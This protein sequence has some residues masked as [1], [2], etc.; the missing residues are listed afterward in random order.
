MTRLISS[1]F[2]L[3]IASLASLAN[4]SPL[5]SGTEALVRN[6]AS[7]DASPTTTSTP[8]TTTT[9]SSAIATKTIPGCHIQGTP[10]VALTSN[11][12]GAT[13]AAD[14]PSC[15]LSCI[16]ISQCI[17]YSYAPSNLACTLYHQWMDNFTT[18]DT[19]GYVV[20]SDTS[21]LFFSD[22]YPSDGTNFCFGD[23][24]L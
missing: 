1:L 18:G 22:K 3:T 19:T 7:Q 14:F 12:W 21:G 24:Q 17:S 15:Q 2:L 11:V 20:L 8:T 23:H 5:N 10:D 9:T 16:Y 4:S 6:P 13:T